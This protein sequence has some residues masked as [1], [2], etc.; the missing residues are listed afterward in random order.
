MRK[1]EREMEHFIRWGGFPDGVGRWKKDNTE[2]RRFL[3]ENGNLCVTEVYLHGNLISR[4]ERGRIGSPRSGHAVLRLSS[5]GWRTVTTKSRI[6]AVL[7]ALDF[8]GGVYQTK[9]VWHLWQNPGSMQGRAVCPSMPFSD[10][11]EIYLA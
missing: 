3:E 11:M 6:N 5:C 2:V 4:E 1:I 9:R 10:G 7:R 8:N